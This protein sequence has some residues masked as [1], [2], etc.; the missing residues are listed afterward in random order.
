M[1]V[2]DCSAVLTM[3]FEDEGGQYAE[4]LF[5]YFLDNS[6]L[7]AQIWPLEVCNTLTVAVRRKRLA[8]A[9]ASHFFRLL[10]ALP[11]E[12]VPGPTT[13]SANAAL[14]ELGAE[15]VP[16][17]GFAFLRSNANLIL[18][19]IIWIANALILFFVAANLLVAWNLYGIPVDAIH[20]V[21]AFGLTVGGKRITFGLVLVAGIILYGAFVS[22]WILQSILMENV[23]NRGHMDSGARI[24]VAR[25]VHYAMVLVGFLIALSTMGFE[26]KNITIIG[27]ALGV[28][29]GFG[30]QTIVNN[31]VC[32][33]IMLFERPLK[34]GD[35]VEFGTQQGRVKQVGLRATV[36]ATYD[37]AESVVP[38]ADL[39]TSQV[40][41]WTLSNRQVRLIL[42]VGVAYG[43]DVPLAMETL[44]ACAKGQRWVA[45]TKAPQVLFLGFGESSL[46]FEL[47]IWTTDADHRL[48]VSSRINQEIDR[49][50]RELGI[51]IAFPQ[52]DL[53]LRSVD[54]SAALR[55]TKAGEMCTES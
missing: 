49:R 22:S 8:K 45:P 33:L 3:V 25:L 47:R 10:S 31:F 18:A 51:E 2:L 24:S 17:G 7:V 46:D 39:I 21:L 29:I 15:S 26:L 36:V 19:R 27:G 50:F 42:P 35:S 43:S 38:N 13:L 55:L 44:A 40:T 20:D 12:L 30:M 6:A 5:N 1:I 52:R 16:M 41:N 23:L 54:A 37:N 48:E 28:G 32:G 53:H 11:V 14:L 34:V 4:K 9:E